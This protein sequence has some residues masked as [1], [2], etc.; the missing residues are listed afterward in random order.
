[1]EH[2]AATLWPTWLR[3][4]AAS[5]NAESQEEVCNLRAGGCCSSVHEQA[6]EQEDLRL[7]YKLLPLDARQ[8]FLHML[9]FPGANCSA[10]NMAYMGSCTCGIGPVVLAPVVLEP[11][12]LAPV[13]LAPVV[14]ALHAAAGPWCTTWGGPSDTS[15]FL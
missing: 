15:A 13:V 6:K 9:P 10:E 11:V 14:L 3:I 12:V 5:R 7:V 1:M 8:G 2:L 4:I